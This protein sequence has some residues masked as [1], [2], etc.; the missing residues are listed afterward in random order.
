VQRVGKYILNN[1][2]VGYSEREF[3]WK[4]KVLRRI[5]R[6]TGGVL[7][8]VSAGLSAPNILGPLRRRIKRIGAGKAQRA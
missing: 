1:A 5:L 2:V 4:M 3:Q 6:E 8:P 7:L